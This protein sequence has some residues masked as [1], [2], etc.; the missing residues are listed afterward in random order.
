[1]LVLTARD[2]VAH[3]VAGLNA[4][5]D[6]YLEKPFDLDELVARVHALLRRAEA[7]PRQWWNTAGCVST[8]AGS[9]SGWTAGK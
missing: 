5:A 4:G 8:R 6:D 3:R 9:E 7:A 1:M 2:G